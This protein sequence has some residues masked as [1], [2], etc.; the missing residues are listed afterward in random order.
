MDMPSN[1]QSM[2][3]NNMSSNHNTMNFQHQQQ[4]GPLDDEPYTEEEHQLMQEAENERDAR[5][6]KV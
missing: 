2:S 6:S 5:F 4:N 1:P 3:M